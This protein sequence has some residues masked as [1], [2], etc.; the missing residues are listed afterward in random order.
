MFRIKFVDEYNLIFWYFEIQ[1]NSKIY[2]DIKK[3]S[4]IHQMSLASIR[5]MKLSD[6]SFINLPYIWGIISFE[7]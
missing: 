6:R 5:S 7:W 1:L 4:F 3:S 2:K